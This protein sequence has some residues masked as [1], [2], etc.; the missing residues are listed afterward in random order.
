MVLQVTDVSNPSHAE[1]D[2]E[3]EKVLEELGVADRP[4]LRVFNKIDR[5]APAELEV[6]RASCEHA[7]CSPE[8]PREKILVSAQT[9]MGVENLIRYIDKAMPVDPIVERRLTVP[10]SHGR[11]LAMIYACGRVLNSEVLDGHIRLQAEVPASLA[12]RLDSFSS[13]Q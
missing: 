3:V 10:M 9:G 13:S 2:A 11:E 12:A 7:P 1:H 5:L 6:L 4:R 8:N